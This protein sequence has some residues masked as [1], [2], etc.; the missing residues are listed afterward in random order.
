MDLLSKILS[1]PTREDKQS[2][3]DSDCSRRH[4]I[5]IMEEFSGAVDLISKVS[6][7]IAESESSGRPVTKQSNSDCIGISQ[8]VIGDLCLHICVAQT[9]DIIGAAL[10]EGQND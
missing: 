5:R 8:P 1:S 7:L 3:L 4:C 10:V 6:P 9:G 2:Q